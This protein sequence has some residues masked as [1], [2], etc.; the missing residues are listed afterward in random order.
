ML[1]NTLIQ[2]QTSLSHAATWAWLGSAVSRELVRAI[3]TYSKP[4]GHDW[5]REVSGCENHVRE[6]V[7]RTKTERESPR[8]GETRSLVSC[9]QRPSCCSFHYSNAAAWHWIN[10]AIGKHCRMRACAVNINL[11]CAAS[12]N[13]RVKRSA[14]REIKEER[15]EEEIMWSLS[16]TLSTLSAITTWLLVYPE[17]EK[18]TTNC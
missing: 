7:E 5:K 10:T 13:K 2:T 15:L 17:T 11:A 14:V 12:T 8:K 1:I 4:H 3:V 6:V 18:D 16:S 9:S